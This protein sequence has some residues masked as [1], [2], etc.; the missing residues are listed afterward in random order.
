MARALGE[1]GVTH[2]LAADELVGHTLAKSLETPQAGDVLLQLVDTT[3]YR[4][5]EAAVD[6]DLVSQP[7]SHARGR[8]GTLVLGIY[9][10]GT[11]DLGV[12]DDPVLQADDRLIVLQPLAS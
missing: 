11:V 1:L 6:Q 7:L 4:L 12:S 2:T 8:A 3:N 5:I 10:D 9:R